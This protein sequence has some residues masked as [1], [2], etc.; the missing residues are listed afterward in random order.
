[1]HSVHCI[2]VK[3]SKMTT[4]YY[5]SLEAFSTTLLSEKHQDEN[6][7]G[8]WHLIKNYMLGVR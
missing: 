7:L 1:M 8:Q 5:K 2:V 4:T 6:S 3:P